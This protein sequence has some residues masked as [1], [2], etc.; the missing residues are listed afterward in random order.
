M[1]ISTIPVQRPEALAALGSDI[2]HRAQHLELLA[3]TKGL[4]QALEEGRAWSGDPRYL[5]AR[6]AVAAAEVTS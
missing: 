2:H 6:A 1:P 5:A 3:A 4:L